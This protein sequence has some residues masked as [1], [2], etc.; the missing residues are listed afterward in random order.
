MQYHEESRQRVLPAANRPRPTNGAAAVLDRMTR[1]LTPAALACCACFATPALADVAYMELDSP[2]IERDATGGGLFGDA[3]TRTL[4]QAIASVRGLAEDDDIEGLV[5]RVRPGFGMN[6][7]QLDEFGDELAAFRA[8]GKPVHVF[9]DNYG[10]LEVLLASYAD[11]A[12][13]QQGGSVMGPRVYMEEMFLADAMARVGLEPSFVQVGDYKG[14]SEMMAN[15]EPSEAWEEN[16]SGLLDSMYANLIERVADGFELDEAGAERALAETFWADGARA[17][18]VGVIDAEIDR[19]DLRAHL[20]KRYGE[21]F[22]F[23][24]GVWVQRGPDMPDFEAMNPFQAFSTLMTM[25]SNEG[26]QR[27]TERETIALVYV[28]GAIVD[29]ESTQGGLLGGA[30][31]GAVTIREALAEAERDDNIK[32]VV[33]RID[34]PGGSATASEVIWQGVRRVVDAGK[35]VWV[36]VGSMAASGGYYIAVAGDRVYVTDNSIVG[37]IGVVGGKIA[38]GGLYEKLDVNVVPRARGPMANM[39]SSLEPWDTAQSAMIR[40]RMTETYDL[41][42]SRVRSGRQG[43]DISKTAE[44]RLFMGDQAIALGMADAVGGVEVALADLAGQ[45][46]LAEGSYDVFEYP[47]PMTFE[48]LLS[49]AIP[50]AAAPE[51]AAKPVL[52]GA[53]REVLGEEAWSKVGTAARAMLELR[54]QP[55]VLTSPRVLIER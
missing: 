30:S 7:A 49:S 44:G 16:I 34:S 19:M 39:L 22:S 40:Q 51:M 27:A 6:S 20:E 2:I 8:S 28:D 47:E 41:F 4:R 43:I 24:R 38:M 46:G 25:L 1:T 29:G 23:E 18:R 42:V 55:V 33:L 13:L 48:E 5:L 37:S 54:N 10:P 26:Q 21:G 11:E 31:V 45:L 32:G 53:L 35:P 3:D 17:K 9:S 12:I 50:F 36:S 52:A 15:S 14:A